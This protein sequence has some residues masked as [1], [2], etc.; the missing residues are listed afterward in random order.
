MIQSERKPVRLLVVED[1]EEDFRFLSLLLEKK[2]CKDQYRLDWA[3]SFEDGIRL[4]GTESYD[5]G[6]FDYNLGGGNGVELLR[7]AVSR[8]LEMPV[9]MLTGAEDPTI[10]EEAL[11]HGAADYLCKIGL[12]S[13]QLERAI[14]Y[15]RRHMRLLSELRRANHLLNSLLDRL[16]VVAGRVDTDGTILETR[17]HGLELVGLGEQDLVGINVFE[18]WPDAAAEI[19]TAVHGGESEFTREVT[20][21]GRRHYFDNYFRFDEARGRGAV[22]LS[23]NVTARVEA[24]NERRREA[25][26]LQSVLRNLPVIAGRL[27]EIGTVTEARGE[28]LARFH[29]APVHIMGQS[30]SEMFPQSREAITR[31]LAG[32]SS[33]FTLSGGSDGDEWSIDFVV[34]FDSAQGRGAT[35]FGRDLSERRKLER[36]ILKVSDAEQQRIGADLHD[37]LGQQLT[38]LACMAAAMRDRLRNKLPEEAGSA[39]LIAQIANEA[40]EQTRAL[41]HG[42]SPVQLEA[43]GL[44]SALEDLTFQAQRLHRIECRFTL[45]GESPDLDHL[46]AIHLYRITQEAIHNAVRHGCAQRVRVGLI[47]RPSRCRLLVLDDGQ[48][49]DASDLGAH[50]GRGLR[51]MNYRAN[52]LGGTLRVQS[53]LGLGVRVICEWPQSRI[54][55]DEN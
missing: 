2:T 16:P 44:A 55:H 10:D 3:P 7:E 17:G 38:G 50:T 34:S 42:L 4:L 14:R 53:C 26:L 32:G 5:A 24:E 37:G 41:A 54:L 29:L 39:D 11:E 35:F 12:T 30:F 52:M 8:G 9:I 31:A 18:A 46:A 1:H 48:G 23:V 20:G 6:L 15:A 51:L 25:Q 40:T 28:S 21:A 13:V 33:S 19:R 43:H 36:Q 49:F 22:A 47:N 45:R 27:D